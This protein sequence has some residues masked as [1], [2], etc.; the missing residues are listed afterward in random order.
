MPSVGVFSFS[1]FFLTF[2]NLLFYIYIYSPHLR[3]VSILM[4]LEVFLCR[5]NSI[6]SFAWTLS[7]RL[8]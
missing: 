2:I 3:Q 4:L 1:Y 8:N 5:F 7:F 6:E